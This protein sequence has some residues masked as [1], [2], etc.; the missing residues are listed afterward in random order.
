MTSIRIQT[1]IPGPRSQALLAERE[2][3]VAGG[4]AT[5]IPVFAARAEGALVED[6]DG[7]VFLDF[8]G[9]IGAQN[10]GHNR[11]EVVHAV[12]EQASRFLHVCAQVTM[13]EEYTAVAQR[14]AA[15]TPGTHAKK[16]MLTNSGAEAVENAVKI[17]RRYTG[18]PGVIALQ[19][20]FHGRTL[21]GM[22]LT[23]KAN[24]YKAG[25]GPFAPDVY[26]A[27]FPYPY[28]MPEFGD[29]AEAVAKACIAEL[30][31]LITVE[32]GADRIAAVIA[33]PVQGEG[34]FIVAPDSYF[35]MLADLCRRH[36][37]LFIADEIQSGFG[38]T[39]K[40][41][42]MEHY[43]VVPD[44][45]VVGKSLAAGLPL[46]AVV[47]RADVV[48][49]TPPGGLGGTYAGNPAACAAA[50]AVMDLFKDGTLLAQGQALGE[51]L[52]AALEEMQQQFPLIGE[53]R[54]LGAMLAAEL[55]TD[56]ETREPASEAAAAIV[57]YCYEHGL[58]LLRC[59]AHGNV[60]R[61]LMP[62]STAPEQLDEGLA[63]LAD[64]FRHVTAG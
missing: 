60:L 35:P 2:Q 50:L 62:L 13:Y 44:L 18:R 49:A 25:F 54:G 31:R 37:I 12:Q 11:P 30:E 38:R 42:A 61:F 43:G 46:A 28:R 10:V 20:A 8:A 64:A 7:N 1:P 29:D 58:L 63:V 3:A 32:V 24:P 48:D 47:G 33:E 23:G 5:S 39:G 27:P 51:R 21:L 26:R 4:L 56:R 19:N 36:G 15:I 40:L 57:R 16:V 6:V 17:A 41:F 55:V 34:G 9:G 53:V 59:G 45:M 14:L 52:R 22:T